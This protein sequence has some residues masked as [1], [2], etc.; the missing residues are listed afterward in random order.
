MNK[1]Q[2]STCAEDTR[3]VKK[4]KP[5]PSVSINPDYLRDKYKTQLLSSWRSVDAWRSRTGDAINLSGHICMEQK[6]YFL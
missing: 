1:R 2:L 4:L 3:T 5:V 6:L